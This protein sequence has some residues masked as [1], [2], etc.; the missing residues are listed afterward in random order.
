MAPAR[1][2]DSRVKKQF[3]FPLFCGAWAPTKGLTAG[4]QGEEGLVVLAGGGGAGR[5]GIKSKIIACKYSF[6]ADELS[7]V[8]RLNITTHRSP[9]LPFR[10]I[11]PLCTAL[12]H[13]AWQVF[14]LST[15]VNPAFKITAHPNGDGLI[16]AFADACRLPPTLLAL[17]TNLFQMTLPLPNFHLPTR[18]LPSQPPLF[19]LPPPCLL[20]PPPHFHPRPALLPPVFHLARLPS[21]RVPSCP[22]PFPP[23]SIL[24]ASLPPVFHL[25]RLPSPRVPS[26]PPPL[27]RPLAQRGSEEAV[28]LAQLQLVP[29]DVRLKWLG[30]REEEEEEGEEKGEGVGGEGEGAGEGGNGNGGKDEGEKGEKKGKGEEG[31]TAA[32]VKCL[33]FSADGCRVVA[34][35]EDGRVRVFE[36]PSMDVL[37]DVPRA[38]T[39]S[40]RD[41]DINLESSLV[42][43]TADTGPLRVWSVRKGTALATLSIAEGGARFGLCR[44]SRDPSKP[45]LYSTCVKGGKGWVVVWETAAW[46][47]VAVRKIH[48][49]PISAFAISP[50]SS[51]LATGTP[52]GNV[53]IVDARTLSVRQRVVGA[54]LVFVTALDFSPN[55][56]ALLSVSGD[57]SARVTAVAAKPAGQG[58]VTCLILTALALLAIALLLSASDLLLLLLGP[59]IAAQV[60]LFIDR[61]VGPILAAQ[62]QAIASRF[63]GPDVAA[64][65]RALLLRLQGLLVAQRQGTLSK[66]DVESGASN[67]GAGEGGAGEGGAG[68][69]GAGE[70]GAGAGACMPQMPNLPHIPSHRLVVMWCD[71]FC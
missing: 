44:F 62:L 39:S 51:L 7:E 43:T 16:A 38:H 63:L 27:P 61:L 19:L 65:L 36:W 23:C 34:G 54:H 58:W 50:D 11:A 9:S 46:K 18:L 13:H 32:E 69:G 53:F 30:P 49:D 8:T 67:G 33:L 48:N 26:C 55:S 22:P 24:P 37:M 25:A 14:S 12:H 60:Q 47:R 4:A 10:I 6:A 52:E 68:E 66:Q 56:R 57:S 64:H 5:H 41:A 29:S 17:E 1:P 31:E 70:G 45:L 3:G 2:D 42:A 59:D 35:S 40:L 71:L 20:P 21:P 15:G 28:P